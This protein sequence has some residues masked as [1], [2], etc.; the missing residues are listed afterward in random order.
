M[1]GG[2][3][4]LVRREGGESIRGRGQEEGM[5]RQRRDGGRRNGEEEERG[6]EGGVRERGRG[7]RGRREEGYGPH[8]DQS[9]R[10]VYVIM[11]LHFSS[12]L[13]WYS[14]FSVRAL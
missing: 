14:S 1:G 9:E 13:R 12:T 11:A 3:E 10:T 8:T 6:E 4:K 7:E 2:K 5:A